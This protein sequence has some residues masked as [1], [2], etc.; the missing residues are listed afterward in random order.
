MGTENQ[1][2]LGYSVHKRPTDTRCLIPHLEKVKSILSNLPDTVITDAG[3][4]G[5][6]N[7]DYLGTERSC[8]YRQIQYL[9][10]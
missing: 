9:P 6:E 4:G 5:E 8:S 7:Y 2:I 3:Y 1:F 10:P